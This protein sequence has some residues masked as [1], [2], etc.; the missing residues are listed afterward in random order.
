MRNFSIIFG[1]GGAG[2]H[3]IELFVES[4]FLYCFQ[5]RTHHHQFYSRNL[6]LGYLSTYF[7]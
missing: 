3:L 7:D 5:D 6:Q 2:L 1:R 4:Y